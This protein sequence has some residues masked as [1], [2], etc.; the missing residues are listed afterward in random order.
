[1]FIVELTYK[2]PLEVVEKFLAEHRAYLEQGYQKHCFIASGPQN[3]RI[4]GIILSQ[5]KDRKE[6]ETILKNDPFTLHDIVDYKIIEFTPVK[7][8]PDFEKFI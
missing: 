8:H 2:K 4:G 7:H 6:L 1:M 3:P 5:L